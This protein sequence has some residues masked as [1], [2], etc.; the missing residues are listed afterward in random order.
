MGRISLKRIRLD[1]PLED[2][3]PLEDLGRDIERYCA[4]AIEPGASD[5][6][7]MSAIEAA[8]IDCYR[9]AT[10]PGWEMYPI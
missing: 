10:T 1:I 8:G 7:P 9:L 3:I 5:S 4:E 2:N 6:R